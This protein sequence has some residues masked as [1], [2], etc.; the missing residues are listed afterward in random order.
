[1]TCSKLA[2]TSIMGRLPWATGRPF[3]RDVNLCPIKSLSN[4]PFPI[5]NQLNRI[6]GFIQQTLQDVVSRAQGVR[7]RRPSDLMNEGGKL[8]HIRNVFFGY[9]V[10]ACS[11]FGVCERRSDLS[12]SSTRPASTRHGVTSV[13]GAPIKTHSAACFYARLRQSSALSISWNREAGFTPFNVISFLGSV[14]IL[15]LMIGMCV[16][17]RL[18]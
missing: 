7:F 16:H 18:H 14:T 17:A 15:L 12:R 6:G 4:R 1:M 9:F 8:Y 13:L 11:P 3:S 10:H 5:F 2:G